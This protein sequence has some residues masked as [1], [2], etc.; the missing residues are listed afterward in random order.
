MIL[1]SN[2]INMLLPAVFGSVFGVITAGQI[3]VFDTA[4]KVYS[5]LMG[6]AIVLA[7]YIISTLFIYLL[8]RKAHPRNLLENGGV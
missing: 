7:V 1:S 8:V 5:A 6:I 2:A 3:R 4:T